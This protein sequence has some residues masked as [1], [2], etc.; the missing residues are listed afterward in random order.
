VRV[1]E[2]RV[3]GLRNLR[4]VQCR[5]GAGFNLVLGG[6]GAGKTSLVEALHVLSHG[7]SFRTGQIDTLIG[8]DAQAFDLFISLAGAKTGAEARLGMRRDASGWT[9][10]QDDQTVPTLVEFVRGVAVVTTEPE[11]HLVVTGTSE[12]RRRFL[13]WLLFHVEPDF[14]TSWRRYL[15]ALRQ[16][17]AALR[18]AASEAA[19]AA[20]EGELAQHGERIDS[21]RRASLEL[22]LPDIQAM[23]GLLLPDLGACQ[24]RYRQGWPRDLGLAEAL[25]VGRASDRERG[26]SQRGPHRSDW[27]LE[28]PSGVGHGQLS[29]GQAKLAAVACLLGQATDYRRRQGQ[30]PIL[31]CD[32]L[33]AE[34]DAE[35]QARL[36][37]WL[38]GTGA[39]VFITATEPGPG[40]SRWLPAD[41]AR[42][43]V[44]QGRLRPLL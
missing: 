5:P 4:A 15:R 38:A 43:H 41:T 19:V 22:L 39:Q 10:R 24:A 40:W 1:T 17:N 30:W 2:L 37:Q 36:L 9:L 6:N 8:R 31:V 29:R 26:F 7:R 34:L 44:E 33:G 12:G 18:S 13:D 16:R 3:D 27:R 14:L 11:S 25:A 32:D 21:Q 28:F 42:F 35:R 20:W 23:L